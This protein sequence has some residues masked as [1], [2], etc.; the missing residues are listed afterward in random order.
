MLINLPNS[1]TKNIRVLIMTK[2][3]LFKLRDERD[4]DSPHLSSVTSANLWYQRKTQLNR[5][6]RESMYWPTDWTILSKS[7]LQPTQRWESY[8]RLNGDEKA[9][10]HASIEKRGS[11]VLIRLSLYQAVYDLK[12]CHLSCDD[13]SVPI[14]AHPTDPP[15]QSC[16]DGRQLIGAWQMK[17]A[18]LT[19]EAEGLGRR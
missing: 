10:P 15:I 8:N 12:A 9:V 6:K 18:L 5:L 13:F 19:E 4:A 3:D 1:S 16:V 7:R 2:W 14:T 17:D 11:S